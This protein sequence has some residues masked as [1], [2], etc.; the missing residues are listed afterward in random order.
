MNVQLLMSQNRLWLYTSIGEWGE[1]DKIQT[2][3]R[4]RLMVLLLLSRSVL[5]DSALNTFPSLLGHLLEAVR[6]VQVLTRTWLQDYQSYE[7]YFILIFQNLSQAL[8]SGT[9]VGKGSPHFPWDSGGDLRIRIDET[10][11]CLSPYSLYWFFSY[12]NKKCN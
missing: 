6:R 1:I 9:K 4:T 11:L 5:E 7:K 10:A 3:I 2:K 8:K 12:P